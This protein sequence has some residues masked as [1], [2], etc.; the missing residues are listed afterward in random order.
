MVNCAKSQNW[1]AFLIFVQFQ[2]N[3]KAFPQGKWPFT[4]DMDS[5]D[6]IRNHSLQCCLITKPTKLESAL[7]QW[8]GVWQGARR[9]QNST[10][11]MP[12]QHTPID[13]FPLNGLLTQ[14]AG[15]KQRLS[16]FEKEEVH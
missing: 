16:S 2:K 13:T 14:T 12:Q 9:L 8:G 5:K 11:G 6:G 15:V 4:S 1:D 10:M 3:V 7:K